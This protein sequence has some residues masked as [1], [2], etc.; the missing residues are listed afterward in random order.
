MV[1]TE[2]KVLSTLDIYLSSF[3][4]LHGIQ[5]ELKNINGRVIFSFTVSDELYRLANAYRV[6]IITSQTK[7]TS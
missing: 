4:A 1:K 5:P 3:L 7:K 2:T 6:Y